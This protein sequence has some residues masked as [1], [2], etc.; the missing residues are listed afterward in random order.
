MRLLTS[1]TVSQRDLQ[2]SCKGL[3]DDDKVVAESS[4]LTVTDPKSREAESRLVMEV[5]SSI[6]GEERRE[7]KRE[8]LLDTSGAGLDVGRSSFTV[9]LARCQAF[10]ILK[11]SSFLALSFDRSLTLLFH[12]NKL[13]YCAG[14]DVPAIASRLCE[15]WVWRQC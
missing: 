13:G 12:P 3:D 6:P 2:R 15:R 10:L 14:S 9:H 5:K 7:L 8:H 1:T 4:M 11:L